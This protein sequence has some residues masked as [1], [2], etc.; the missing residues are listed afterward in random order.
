MNIVLPAI[1]LLIFVSS[2]AAPSIQQPTFFPTQD[3]QSFG[4]GRGL[5]ADFIA[6]SPPPEIREDKRFNVALKFANHH[7]QD[8]DAI[9]RVQ[10]TSGT[11][12]FPLVE[13]STTIER[14][15]YTEHL[16]TLQGGISYVTQNYLGPGC[17]LFEP[18]NPIEKTV[19]ANFAYRNIDFD[20][21][22]KFLA[23]IYYNYFTTIA[24]PLRICN[25][26]LGA[27]SCAP[28]QN[29]LLPST[30]SLDPVAVTSITQTLIGS[31]PLIDRGASEVILTLDI[32]LKNLGG[33]TIRDFSSPR[34]FQT[35]TFSIYSEDG[36]RFTCASPNLIRGT[37]TGQAITVY[38]DKSGAVDIS[39]D[40]DAPVSQPFTTPVSI[41]L[42]Y[43]YSYH[44]ETDT[45]T[46]KNVNYPA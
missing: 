13:D 4:P 27:Y 7:D 10:D 29:A 16:T 12:Q 41:E 42:T 18:S 14:A 19:A 43:P 22:I 35:L 34:D 21:D 36:L 25:P 15:Q 3:C 5:V 23:D 38:L 24:V 26:A 44:I 32:S 11:R 17:R 28:V 1:L 33:G 37:S 39:C 20:E 9:I 6:T 40:A 31:T 46:L 45:I 2:C 30:A 8:I